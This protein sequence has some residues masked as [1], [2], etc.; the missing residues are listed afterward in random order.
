MTLICERFLNLHTS[1]IDSRSKTSNHDHVCTSLDA[2]SIN[3]FSAKVNPKF[4]W[5][6]KLEKVAS[7]A[8]LK[9]DKDDAWRFRQVLL[10][11]CILIWWSSFHNRLSVDW[12]LICSKLDHAYKKGKSFVHWN[13]Y[14]DFS[15]GRRRCKYCSER[16]SGQIGRSSYC[17]LPMCLLVYISATIIVE[18]MPS[19]G[20]KRFTV[21]V[22]AEKANLITSLAQMLRM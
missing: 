6:L 3:E 19:N 14:A 7:V 13:L 11:L 21:H 1:L 17:F 20:S 10:R 15:R 22:Y 2:K 5:K 16:F 8:S 12:Q 9:G 18:E 4:G